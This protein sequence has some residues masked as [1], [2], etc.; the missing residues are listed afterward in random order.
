MKRQREI[1]KVQRVRTGMALLL[2]MALF[3]NSF[4]AIP[5]SKANSDTENKKQ[6]FEEVGY[7]LE[8]ST[9]SSWDNGYVAEVVVTNT[10]E[11]DIRNWSVVAT[12]EQGDIE[13]SWNV[14]NKKV[15]TQ[16]VVFE[17]ESHNLILGAGKSTSFGFQ[18]TDGAYHDIMSLKLVQGKIVNTRKAD[19][20]FKETSSWDG[21]KIYEGI[22]TNNSGTTMR[23]WSLS[24]EVE[25]K[26]TNIWNATVVS[27][28]D[29]AFYIKNCNY[30]AVI[31]DGASV[32][33]GF[34]VSYATD[35][36]SG[37][38]NARFYVSGNGESDAEKPMVTEPPVVTATPLPAAT[39]NV[40]EEPAVTEAPT[41]TPAVN[42]TPG[43]EEEITEDD[44]EF[45]QVENRDWNM[46]MIRANDKEVEPAK[47]PIGRKI[48]VT[49]LDSGINYSE[50]VDVVERRNFVEGEDEMSYLFED[51][52]GHGTAIA[53]VLASNPDAVLEEEDDNVEFVEE[54]GE[55]TY[56]GDDI[57]EDEELDDESDD[58]DGE[59]SADEEEDGTVSFGELLDS[60]YE[61]TEGVNPNIELYSGK[62][63]DADNETTV[64][65]AVA[66]IEW[67]IENDTDILS[68]SIGMDKD[69]DKLHEAIKK[70][71]ASGMLII[72]A[73]GDDEKVDYPA[74]YPEVMSVGMV[75]SMGETVG[76]PAE[77]VAP[78]EGIVSRG[79]FDSMQIFSGSSMAVP[80]VVGLASILW[81]KDASKDAAFIRGL[82]DV[83]ANPIEGDE[84]CQYGLIDCKYALESY[85]AFEET[86][87]E[88]RAVL[89]D[90]SKDRNVE[91]VKEE[92]QSE[93]DNESEVV[94]EDEMEKVHGNW[95]KS[96][97]EKFV[98]EDYEGKWKHGTKYVDVLQSG[99]T[100]IDDKEHNKKC[101]GMNDHPWF[102]GFFGGVQD[103]TKKSN[104][105]TSYRTLVEMADY[106]RK[107]GK[108]MDIDTKSKYSEVHN[109]L[110]GIDV[111]FDGED[112]IG[113]QTWKDINAY[114][115]KSGDTVPKDC[116]SL[117]IYGMAL[118]TLADTFSHSS[119]GM[120]KGS[121]S[122]KGSIVWRRY[123][124]KGSNTGKWYADNTESRKLRYDAAKNATKKGLNRIV[125][126]ANGDVS[127][128]DTDNTVK[129]FFSK[130]QFNKLKKYSVSFEK[131]QEEGKPVKKLCKMKYFEEGFV[132]KNFSKYY[133][134]EKEITKKK[135][136]GI[137][138]YKKY[139]DKDE[140]DENINQYEVVKLVD[141]INSATPSATVSLESDGMALTSLSITADKMA[142]VISKDVEYEITST[143]AR[144]TYTLC[145]IKNGIVYDAIGRE[146][147]VM[148]LVDGGEEDLDEEVDETEDMKVCDIVQYKPSTD[149]LVRGKVVYFDYMVSSPLRD[150][151]PGL[152]GVQISA[153]SPDTGKV[154][155]T[156]TKEDGSYQFQM[157]VGEYDVTYEKDKTYTV[158][159]QCLEAI[160][161]GYNNVTVM[162]LG[163][164]W[165]GEGCMEGYLYD[166][167]TGQTITEATIQI[168]KGI[169][170]YGDALV[171]TSKTSKNGYFVTDFLEAGAYT[172]VVSKEGYE[173]EYYYEP[174]IGGVM[175]CVPKLE[176]ARKE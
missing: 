20:E 78:G 109:A 171:D 73:V 43:T 91:E 134:Q 41:S 160:G 169:G 23:D 161:D 63:L 150:D 93:I 112:K 17:S 162:M 60:G 144:G 7:K 68:L 90:V 30:N 131:K 22:I 95:D 156:T 126:D 66:G 123:T 122:E 67:A 33:F 28:E 72:A 70:A 19:L 101:Y 6:V 3:M 76:I 124:H 133:E 120:K 103:G 13:R 74:A 9:S 149:C 146:M 36:F 168:Y 77:V 113:S 69:S 119:F 110:Y 114:C 164:S 86:V 106:M 4:V 49:M 140:V 175:S 105:M 117:L 39:P 128:K 55:Y 88:N 31:E 89:D 40:T 115:A 98:S 26:I 29:G 143:D 152:S 151:M 24:F 79:I 157:P 45:V 139:V 174:I 99:I 137:E 75:N 129:A 127:Y 48:K 166:K 153:K 82:M 61:W 92:V 141:V 142:F 38:H 1:W 102:H 147:Q 34:E 111:A 154:Y 44:I 71:V 5:E 96:L 176:L 163:K 136:N 11:E 12:M 15:G 25:G 80:H 42:E 81:Q 130:K 53:E 132:L 135:S 65:R 59:D 62:I 173:T 155:K 83:S 27:E 104:Y 37:I 21:H 118:H 170:Y 97:H 51:G 58:E 2:I 100:F 84:S 47:K 10:G 50:E 167:S 32:T 158:V 138:N 56:Y 159:E 108:V 116:R 85:G 57:E 54:Y 46:D 8:L 145:S 18:V 125:V 94:T 121:G 165:F 148:N 87:R 16:E 64:D 172:F 35:S 52:S 14:T 107:K